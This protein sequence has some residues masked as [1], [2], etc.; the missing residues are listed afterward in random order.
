[1]NKE[2]LQKE[3]MQAVDGLL[4]QSEIEA[5]FEFVYL[6]QPQ[7]RQ[8]RPEDVVEHAGKPS[9]MAVKVHTL[10]EFLSQMQ[11]VDSDVR[12]STPDGQAA[13]R[14]LTETLLRLLQDVKVYSIT[15]IGTE[16]Y[17]LGKAEDGNYAGLRTMFIQDEA[18]IKEE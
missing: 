6:E 11:G 2:Q 18:S 4:M 16:A 10:E 14:R 8:L 17:I 5:P 9:G 13:Y 1:M 12:K 15:Q 3:L 7:G